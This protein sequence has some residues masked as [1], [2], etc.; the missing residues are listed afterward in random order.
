MKVCKHC[1]IE[2]DETDFPMNGN[3][4]HSWCKEC[5][6]E[7]VKNKYKENRD[8][9]NTLKDKCSICGYNK[10]KAALEFHH[11]DNNKECNVN[12]LAKR[13]IK[14]RERVL[15]E[16]EKCELLCANCHREIHYPQ[17]NNIA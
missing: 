9:V 17:L 2:K 3:R 14:N 11:P 12:S 16:I 1:L 15:K 10:N 4:R 5:H 8:W 7:N 6:R 13:A